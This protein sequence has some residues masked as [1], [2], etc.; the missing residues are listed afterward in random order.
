MKIIWKGISIMGFVKYFIEPI[1]RIVRTI[2]V[3]S[4]VT[5]FVIMSITIIGIILR[6]L[7]EP[8]SG[9]TNLSESLL[10]IAIYCGIAYAQQF[11]QHVAVE[12]LISRLTKSPKKFLSII[13]LIIPFGICTILIFICW[14]YALESWNMREKMDGA[15]FYPIYPPKIA[16]AVGISLLWL[17]LLADLLREIMLSFRS[18][19]D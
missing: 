8:L 12:F 1:D 11:K 2:N 9:L 14:N 7:G 5:F 4:M 18:T 17:Q 13:N 10:I 3:I 19:T 15:P 6:I 16:I